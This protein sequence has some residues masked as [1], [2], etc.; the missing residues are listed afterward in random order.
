MQIFVRT[1]TETVAMSV[2]GSEMIHTIKQRIQHLKGIPV[3]IQR[4]ALSGKPLWDTRALSEYKVANNSTLSL[5]LSMLGAG[6]GDAITG[7]TGPQGPQGPKGDTGAAGPQGPYGGRG[8]EGPM[9]ITGIQGI[10]GPVGVRGPRG[11][12]GFTAYTTQMTAQTYAD[13]DGVLGAGSTP[14]VRL[15]SRTSVR[16]KPQVGLSGESATIFG[17]S[18]DTNST[19]TVPQG[20]YFIQG[21]ASVSSNISTSSWLLLSTFTSSGT[22]IADIAV[23]TEVLSAGVVVVEGMFSFPSPTYIKLR[24]KGASSNAVIYPTGGASSTAVLSFIRL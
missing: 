15:F 14:V 9:G 18:V 23:G 10:Q 2:E 13:T 24:H 1:P 17:L 11:V 3:S 21:A 12:K 7:Y 5:S 6:E 20:T 4:L 19:F 16:N 22:F 8:P